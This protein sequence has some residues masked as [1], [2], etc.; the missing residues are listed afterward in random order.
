MSKRLINGPINIVRLEGTVFGIKKI[1][2]VYMDQHYNIV[3]QTQCDGFNA[4]D[5]S[6]HFAQAFKN[7]DKQLDF[8]FEIQHSTLLFKP[9]KYRHRYIDE[10]ARL[11][12]S[13]DNYNIKENKRSGIK[14]NPKVRIHYIDIRD[15][16]GGPAHE[17]FFNIHENTYFNICGMMQ[18]DQLKL[19]YNNI[20][21]L[22]IE[23]IPILNIYIKYDNQ[24]PMQ[25]L[26]QKGGED[27]EKN[28]DS[29][30]QSTDHIRL[31]YYI[32]KLQEK[33]NHSDVLDKVTIL[34]DEAYDFFK[35][36]IESIGEIKKIIETYQDSINDNHR[37]IEYPLI[38]DYTIGPSELDIID[39]DAQLKKSS[40]LIFYYLL[41]A[42]SLIMDMFFLRR[43]LDKDYITTSVVYT[44]SNH[45]IKYI[46]HLV[47]QFDFKVTHYSYSSASDVDDLNKQIKKYPSFEKIYKIKELFIPPTITQCSD[48]TSFP[49]NFD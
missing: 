48:M 14:S 38:K 30:E 24:K 22:S 18:D 49:N 46:Q 36:A 34:K 16:I 8:F 11:F 33:Y 12:R 37:V 13:E 10:V 42:F 9:S 5:I 23:L 32:K 21:N 45:S 39:R 31:Q 1:L 4:V 19:L 17:L 40:Y 27:K 2:Y 29:K 43:F 20:K 25:K 44:G 26:I 7:T 3:D 47:N 41:T 15:Y 6:K 28:K 35:G